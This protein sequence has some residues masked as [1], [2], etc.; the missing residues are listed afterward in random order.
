MELR[1]ADI[2]LTI[3]SMAGALSVYAKG[4][5]PAAD[6][7]S[8]WWVLVCGRPLERDSQPQREASR[9]SL[10]R[11]MARRHI[12]QAEHQWVWDE[13]NRAQ[14][15][16]ARFACRDKAEACRRALT[17]VELEARVIRGWSGPAPEPGASPTSDPDPDPH[18]D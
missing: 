17:A 11:E 10:L 12:H 8:E 3:W 6:P 5:D 13:T 16:V 9:N 14:V 15:V 4:K 1:A 18:G 7:S 2:E